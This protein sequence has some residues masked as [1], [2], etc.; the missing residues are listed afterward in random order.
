MKLRNCIFLY[1]IVVLFFS[2]NKKKENNSE[3]VQKETEQSVIKVE[4]SRNIVKNKSFALDDEMR[5]LIRSKVTAT[6]EEKET[7]KEFL[8]KN[9][10]SYKKYYYGIVYIEKINFGIHGGENW[11]VRLNNRGIIIY[12]IKGELIEKR[13][14]LTSF[15][16]DDESEF[17][18]M[19]KI[20]GTRIDNST[21]SFGDFNGDGKDEIFEYGF[22]GRG[23]FIVIWGYDEAEDD[24]IDYCEIPFK[25]IDSKNGPAP[26]E[27]M[28][29]RG[30]F[31]FKVY[32]FNPEVAGGIGWV[33][34]P[35][36]KNGKWIFYTWDEEQKK[37]VEIGE[38][39]E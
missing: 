31:G 25:I 22:Y 11:I 15:N 32:Y 12:A 7:M 39:V 24:Y 21:S 28:T 1:I 5:E 17:D 9:D 14:Y 3:S 29:Y 13:Y 30:M 10:E 16:L 19:Q 33:P 36:P 6:D 35:D 26:V 23:F 18:I 38:V 37:Y 8:Y 20:P 4:E 2:C 34:D 27:F